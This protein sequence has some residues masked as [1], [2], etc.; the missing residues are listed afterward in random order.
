MKL[1]EWARK[2]GIAYLTAYRWFKAGHLPVRAEQLPTGTI[3]VYED[4]I[5]KRQEKTVIY[6]RV[7]NRERKDSLDT[8]VSRCEQFCLA[9]GW[10][11]HKSHKEIASGMNDNRQEFWRMLESKPSRI[12]VE[13]KDRL[14]RFGFNYLDR[15]LKEMGC[16]IIVV[17]ASSTDEDDLV[18]DLISI[19]TSFCCRLYGLRRCKN[20]VAKIKEVLLDK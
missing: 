5:P 18:K 14:T 9:N 11:V 12:V 19:V 4:D 7:S 16:E 1:P 17:N 13:N 15:L 20:K 2:N 6:C 8:Q 10:S 3:L